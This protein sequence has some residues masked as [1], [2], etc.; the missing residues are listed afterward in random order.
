REAFWHFDTKKNAWNTEPGEYEVWVGASSR[1][2]REKRSVM[3][4]PEPRDTRL[5]TGLAIKTLIADPDGRAVL[6]KYAGGSP[7]IDMGMAGEMTLEQI[8]SSYPSVVSQG[9][10]IEIEKDLA[11]IP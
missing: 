4:E 7:L 1:D 9:S 10:L 8:A 3:L 2:V 5:H 6:L 11:K